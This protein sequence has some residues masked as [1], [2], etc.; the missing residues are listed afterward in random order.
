MLVDARPATSHDLDDLVRLYAEL[1]REMD[2]LSPLWIGASGLPGQPTMAFAAALEDP[3]T[4]VAVGRIDEQVVGF[5]LVRAEPLPASDRTMAAIRYIFTELPAREVGVA[6]AILEVLLEAME[7]RGIDLF[8]AHV[9][10][11]H[12]LAKNFFESAG[13]K[14]RHIVMHRK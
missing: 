11:G 10:P 9:L 3:D 12:R 2:D 4:V 6:A 1:E 8:D 5:G 14:A 13:F 7:G